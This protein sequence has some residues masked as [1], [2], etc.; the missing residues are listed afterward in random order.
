MFF[1]FGMF[2]QLKYFSPFLFLD[3]TVGIDDQGKE[4]VISGSILHRDVMNY[5]KGVRFCVAFNNY[6]QPIRKGGYI[7]VRFLGYIAR[8]ERSSPIGTAS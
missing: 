1:Q 3:I 6:N 7:F 2:F 4:E 5:K 8:Q